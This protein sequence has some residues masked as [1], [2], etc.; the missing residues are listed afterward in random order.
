M[1]TDEKDITNPDHVHSIVKAKMLSA[2]TDGSFLPK[3]NVTRGAFCKILQS[4][5][6]GN[7]DFASILCFKIAGKWKDELA[8]YIFESP[9]AYFQKLL[10]QNS[11]FAKP[12]GEQ[13]LNSSFDP[14]ASIL[15]ETAVQWLR[16]VCK[17]CYHV[18]IP[19]PLPIPALKEFEN[20]DKDQYATRE[21]IAEAL[22]Q[23]CS[24]IVH[25]LEERAAGD[26]SKFFELWADCGD[27]VYDISFP[28]LN[29]LRQQNACTADEYEMLL[30]ETKDKPR[31]DYKSRIPV[32]YK[33]LCIVKPIWGQRIY[34]GTKAY[35]Y[36]SLQALKSMLDNAQQDIFNRLQ[37]QVHMSNAEFLNDPDEGYIL[38]N[39]FQLDEKAPQ[40]EANEIYPRREYITCL[41][42]EK[43]EKLPMWVQYGDG[44]KGCR[45]EFLL[46]SDVNF[47]EVSYIERNNLSQDISDIIKSMEKV[48]NTYY[49][50]DRDQTSPTVSNW[51]KL[52]LKK[53]GYIFKDKYYE[54]EKEIRSI[55]TALPQQVKLWDKPRNGEIFP[56]SYVILKKPLQVLSVTLG[57]KCPNPEQIAVALQNKGIN[58]I[59]RSKIHFQ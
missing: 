8:G 58:H 17:S 5:V 54:Q 52:L 14:T 51:A 21:W 15:K 27:N 22:Y 40:P 6:I 2:Y 33:L 1:F 38:L 30:F 19:D 3:G 9:I 50:Q 31:T 35:Q 49:E 26:R 36:T 59:Y 16:F 4:F 47:Y 53:Y 46:D 28:N 37:F 20:P 24:E 43:E 39:N 10:L 57:P 29:I 42:T 56:R 45:I 44:G 18:D 13:L 7:S 32:M 34:S 48:V 12:W 23:C 25:K 41:S 55:V 11:E